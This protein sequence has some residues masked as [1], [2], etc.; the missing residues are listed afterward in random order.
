LRETTRASLAVVFGCGG[1][2]DRGK[3]PQMG[4]VAA[5]L[6]DRIYVTSDNPR[7]EDPQTIVDEIVAGIGP[8]EHVVELDRRHAIARAIAEAAPGDIV[9]VAGKGHETYQIVGE[10]VLPFDDLAIA[11]ELLERRAAS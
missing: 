8:H 3:R 7:S 5:G 10:R 11:R 1:D 6:A 9:L 4:A 2:R